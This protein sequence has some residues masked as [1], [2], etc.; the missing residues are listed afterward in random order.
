M[1]F[2]SIGFAIF[3][4][5]VIIIYFALEEKS[6]RAALIWLLIADYFYYMCAGAA[7][8]ALLFGVTFV[9]YLCGRVCG[10]IS[11]SR[12][13]R[14]LALIA[15]CT[16]NVSLLV[17]FKYFNLFSEMILKDPALKIIL[18]VGVSF[19]VFSSLTY[20]IDTYRGEQ[21]VQKD[22]IKYALFVSFFPTLL[23]GPIE[24]S[25]NLLPQF[26]RPHRF[27]YGKAKRG[28]IKMAVGY[29]MKLVIAQRLAITVDLI[30]GNV[31]DVSGFLLLLA[32]VF[33]AFQI[34][35]DFASYS[36]IA[37]GLATV[38][39]FEVIE[40]FRQP[41]FAKSCSDLWRRWHISLN[42]WFINY[43]Y[44][45]LGGSR[46][47][48]VRKYLNVMAVFTLSGMWHGAA[49]HY[50]LWGMLSGLFQVT[51]DMTKGIR[52][53]ISDAFPVHN[54][55][56]AVLHRCFQVFLTFVFFVIALV[57]FRADSTRQAFTVF[58]KI[59][60]GMHLSDIAAN[61]IFDLGLGTFNMLYLLAGMVLLVIYD[62]INE[63][64]GDAA[65]FI[66]KRPTYLRWCIYYVMILMMLGS[67]AIGAKQF[68]YFDF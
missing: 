61:S 5:L 10:N 67:A 40:N 7:F 2:N 50:V 30:Y 57:F 1:L 36:S 16:V 25:V 3:C 44:I 38:L 39:G 21:K 8:G 26:D 68:I 55:N 23:A 41:F 63:K 14:H 42:N 22:F 4:P 12:G 56:T 53:K 27:D 19:Y 31:D 9:T 6:H 24:R 47:G 18:P 29:F 62:V 60:A 11:F 43:V 13:W 52:Q 46:K 64:T 37:S 51:G 28:L 66:S 45:P 15:G 32:T 48:R 58:G 54:K 17:F 35:C 20:V 65:G 59:F 34:Y 33:Y 49:L